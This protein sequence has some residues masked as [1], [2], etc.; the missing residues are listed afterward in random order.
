MSNELELH[1]KI[2][3][4]AQLNYSPIILKCIPMPP[5][6]NACYANNKKESGRGRIKT[7][8]Y[9]E[10]EQEML[11]WFWANTRLV[12][13]L[14]KVLQELPPGM[15]V[16]LEYDFYFKKSSI[17]TEENRPKRNDTANRLK[18]LDDQLATLFGVDDS[19]FWDGEF[20]KH[21]T[22]DEKA[23]EEWVDVT[24]SVIDI[25]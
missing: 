24:I 6:V 13:M 8:K 12:R 1:S 4:A 16:K 22:A 15:A 19:L 11:L 3:R 23:S 21:F 7:K 25:I 14:A 17:I 10:F 18:P 9:R 20:K 2:A 5:S